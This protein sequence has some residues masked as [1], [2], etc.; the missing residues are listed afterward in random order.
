MIS[1]C[2]A[3]GQRSIR[4]ITKL[5]NIYNIYL[6]KKNKDLLRGRENVFSIFNSFLP[7]FIIQK[8]LFE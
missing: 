3:F 4:A 1:M 6:T 2:Q 8:D 5:N 7:F